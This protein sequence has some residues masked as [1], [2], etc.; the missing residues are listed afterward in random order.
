[1]MAL[2]TLLTGLEPLIGQIVRASDPITILVSINRT[3]HESQLSVT[4]PITQINLFNNRVLYFLFL[5]TK[6]SKLIYINSVTL[7]S[8]KKKNFLT[9]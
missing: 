3:K 6:T 5:L 8:L 2:S 7:K 1:M 9:I 4:Q